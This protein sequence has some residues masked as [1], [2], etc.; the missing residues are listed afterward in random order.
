MDFILSI[1]RASLVA[2]MVKN[3]PALWETQ[4]QS[5]G[6]EELL[7]EGMATHSSILAWRIAWTEKLQRSLVGYSSWGLQ[8][9]GHDWATNTFSMVRTCIGLFEF[10][11]G[12]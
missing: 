2:Q 10:G 9:V 11:L 6:Q 8:R 3:L 5:L 1:V 4:G 7:E 12:T